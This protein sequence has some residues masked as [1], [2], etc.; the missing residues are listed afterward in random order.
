[1][2][3]I[4]PK[5]DLVIIGCGA[6]AGFF[7]SLMQEFKLPDN[8]SVLIIEKLSRPFKKIM[9]SGNGRCN[10]SNISINKENYHSINPDA[11][12]SEIF[13][14]KLKN[15]N[16][17]DYFF[18]KGIPSR[19]DEYGRIFPY[20]NSAKTIYNFFEASIRQKN[21]TVSFDSIVTAIKNNQDG[22]YETQ[23]ANISRPGEKLSVKSK[24]I[25]YAAGGAAYPQLGTDGESFRL[26][27]KLGIKTTRQ[28]PAIAALKTPKNP[29]CKLSGLK[30]ETEIS[31]FNYKRKGE[32]LFTDYGISGPNV[33][34]ASCV[35]SSALAR[36]KKID[37]KIDFLPEE[38]LSLNYF[39]ELLKNAPNKTIN[40][41]FGGCLSIDF[42]KAF[43][44]YH[45]LFEIAEMQKLNHETL[46]KIYN[47][48][49]NTVIPVLS[50]TSFKEAQVS[51]GGVDCH[52]ITP[53]TL[54][55]KNHK[56]LYITGEAIDFTGE[57]G[58][59]NIHQ[60]AACALTVLKSILKKINAEKS[61]Q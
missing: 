55:A 51:L 58:G 18:K 56:N 29:F 12:F 8:F 27:E 35:I 10:Y 15:L 26:I 43:L 6:A 38:Y 30:M 9:A 1:M 11:T 52:E 31:F 34:Y 23:F 20:T 2:N 22:L 37:V 60:A 5:Y 24:F 32:L 45:S 16:L 39:E 54:E 14:T 42:I 50:V 46:T 49:K 4:N 47:Q 48:L 61:V 17:K 40:G 21:I 13:F 36:Q 7:T 19:I 44:E 57:C 53:E 25:I 28:F 59:Y 33:L 41:I 3:R